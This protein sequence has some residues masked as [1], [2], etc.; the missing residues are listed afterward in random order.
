M[1]AELIAHFVKRFRG[2]PEIRIDFRQLTEGDSVTALFGPSGCG[3]TTLLRCLAGLTHPDEGMIT[4]NDQVWFSSRSQIARSPQQRDIGFLFQDYA[5]F[6]HL[7]VAANI[8]F[9]IQADPESTQKHRIGEMLD[10][11]NLQGLD[12]RFPRQLSGGQQQRVAL[13]RTVAR[14]PQLLLLDEPL[15]ALDSLLRDQLRTELRRILNALGM[16]TIIVTHDRMEAISLA[17]RVAL[18]DAGSIAQIG[19]VQDVFTRPQ[20]VALARLVGVE[21]VVSGEIVSINEGLSVV[22]VGLAHLMAVARPEATRQVYVCIKGEDVTLQKEEPT[23][24][25][26]RNHLPGTIL[27]LTPEG[28]LVR[29]VVNCGFELTSLITRPACEELQLTPGDSIVAL[30]K[31]PAIHLIPRSSQ[32]ATTSS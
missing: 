21:T 3:K 6:P 26:V 22:H 24:S 19:S 5:L 20:N 7:T 4:F 16:P 15:S 9:G 8:A 13:A 32:P 1:T 2:G 14:R 12:Q 27:S 17:D 23:F 31:A 11:F 29:V 28:P 10:L 30:L 25:S 18:M